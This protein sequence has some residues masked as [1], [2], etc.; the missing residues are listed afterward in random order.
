MEHSSARHV[1]APS[2]KMAEG[3]DV[4][5]QRR[6]QKLKLREYKRDYQSYEHVIKEQMNGNVR[7]VKRQTPGCF[8]DLS[9]TD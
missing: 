4:T 7:D 9:F 2:S 3:T 1:V 5:C 8:G 6:I